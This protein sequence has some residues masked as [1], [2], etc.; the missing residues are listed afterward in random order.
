MLWPVLRKTRRL[1]NLMVRLSTVKSR[2]C[3][4]AYV[5]IVSKL[6]V[7][8]TITTAQDPT[9]K[10]LEVSRSNLTMRD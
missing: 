1:C 4:Q 6:A 9:F 2:K 7:L 8:H 10:L 3:C 5:A